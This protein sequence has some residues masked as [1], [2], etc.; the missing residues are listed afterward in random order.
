VLSNTG[1]IR[2]V[3]NMEV[4]STSGGTMYQRALVDAHD[5]QVALSFSLIHIR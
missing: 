2:L 5:G 1:P 3:W 4:W